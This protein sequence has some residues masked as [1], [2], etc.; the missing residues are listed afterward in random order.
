MGVLGGVVLVVETD[1][2]VLILPCNTTFFMV[3]SGSIFIGS[4]IISF[5]RT[6]SVLWYP[7]NSYKYLLSGVS[8]FIVPN[9][10]L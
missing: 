10:L 3:P 4:P 5:S 6:P 7:P 8:I 9:I 2:M 1:S